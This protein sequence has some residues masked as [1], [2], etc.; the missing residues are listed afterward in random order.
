[1]QFELPVEAET[2]RHEVR[3]FL[4]EN[5]SSELQWRADAGE[6]YEEERA[7]RRKLGERGWLA[8]HWPVQFG[9]G[10]RSFW[11]AVVIAE[12]F[13]YGGVHTSSTAIRVVGPTLM[14]TGSEAQ[15]AAFL[16]AIAR[17]EID[18]A[19]GYTEPGA[20]SDLASLQTRA[21]RDGDSFV[22][23]GSK[24]FTSMAHRAEYCW[25]AARTDP[26]APKHRGISL[27]IVDL[28]T[29]GIL[30]RPLHTMAHGRTNATYWDDVRVPADA[31]VGELDRGWYAMTA[32]LDLER[33]AYYTPGTVQHLGE[34]LLNHLRSP[35]GERLRHERGAREGMVRIAL[36]ILVARLLYRRAAWLVSLGRVPNYEA[37]MSKMFVTEL[38][39]WLPA[40]AT[41]LLGPFGQLEPGEPAAPMGGL[42]ELEHRHGVYKTFG[43]GSSELMRNIIAQRGMG[44]PRG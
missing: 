7:L 4:R 35:E 39:Q 32:A 23:N 40:T 3:E 19:L 6:A 25:L 36:D 27:F 16:P 15:K 29:P 24:I 22:I 44:L 14:L 5:W 38:E 12:E 26:E 21:T 2:L 41:R 34:K 8:P 33:L 30:V 28:S 1:M 9:G 31:L 43:G 37:S 17:G 11:E 13:Q 18:F 42:M 10:G 20:G